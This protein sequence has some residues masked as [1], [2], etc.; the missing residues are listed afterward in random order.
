MEEL[1]PGNSLICDSPQEGRELAITLARKSIK[2]VQPDSEVL[3]AGRL[4]YADDP[5]ALIDAAHVVAIEFATIAAAN[6]YWREPAWKRGYR[7]DT[8]G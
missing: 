4:K 7:P 1:V 8:R 5:G 6:H 2:A 3:K